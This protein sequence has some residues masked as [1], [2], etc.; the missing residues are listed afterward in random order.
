MTQ[1]VLIVEDNPLN[2]ELAQ[3]ILE[4]QGYEVLSAGDADA[5]L[6]V[7]AEHRPH[8]ILMDVQLP[9]KDGLQLTR[10]LR[11][12]PATRDLPIVAMT[13]HALVEDRQRVLDAGCDGY[14]IKPIQTRTLGREVAAFIAARRTTAPDTPEAGQ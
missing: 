6:A 13:A 3:D 9:G 14:L 2:L 8:L 11:A 4:A 10:E 1:S 12:N 5:C 7:L